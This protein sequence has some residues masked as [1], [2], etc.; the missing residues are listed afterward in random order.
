M[1]NGTTPPEPDG[2]E[3]IR[4]MLKHAELICQYRGEKIG[5]LELRKHALWYTKGLR[6]SAQMRNRFS[7]LRDFSELKELAQVILDASV[8]S[9]KT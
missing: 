7:T 4:I 3:K 2:E 9:S 1:K 6:G 8:R 5:M